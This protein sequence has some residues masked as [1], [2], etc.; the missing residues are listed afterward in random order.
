MA[1]VADTPAYSRSLVPDS[2]RVSVVVCTVDREVALRDTL[3]ALR[4]QTFSAFEVVVV[5][6]PSADGTA[7][8]LSSLGDAVR[9]RSNPERHLSRSRNL[10]IAAAAGDLVAFLDDDAVPE[11]RWL[12]ELVAPF[13]ADA[14][15]GAAGGLVLDHTGVRA[16]WRHL[17]AF[18][19]GDHDFDRLPPFDDVV[20]PG[21]DPFLYVPGGNSAFRRAALAEI[22]GFDEEIEYNFDETEVCL[23]LHDAGWG[24][25]SLDG[26]TVHHRALPSHLRTDAAFVD[27]LFEVK[28]RVYFGL[29]HGRATRT[30]AE[31]LAAL[32]RHVGHLR[33][34]A[35]DARVRGR[36]TDAQLARYLGRAD[37]GFHLGL[38]RGL[39][40]ARRGV[41]IPP[42]DGAAFAPYPVLTP[43]APR[44]RVAVIGGR[45]DDL[46]A[47]G[48]EVHAILPVAA[49]EPYRVGYEAGSWVR[50]VPVNP[51]WSA[52]VDPRVA[53]I[54]G[55]LADIGEAEVLGDPGPPVPPGTPFPVDWELEARACLDASADDRFVDAVYGR[56]LGR[57]PD[58]VGRRAM[59]GALDSGRD[60]V[61]VL[62]GVFAGVEAR[63][64]GIPADLADRLPRSYAAAA[65]VL[66]GA[67]LEADDGVFAD[68]AGRLLTGA[69]A[70]PSADRRALV[71]ALAATPEARERVARPQALPPGD[72]RTP[73][74]LGAGLNA[75]A[76][77][78]DFAGG[79]YRLL[80]GRAPD[81]A[82]VYAV[83]EQLRAGRTRAEVLVEL[84]GSEEA[85]RRGLRADVV[86]R[87]VGERAFRLQ[88]ALARL[89]RVAARAGR[90]ASRA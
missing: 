79:A 75:L 51:H 38:Q 69:P 43:D 18:R 66:R 14:R 4:R 2:L 86:E 41:V 60:R 45:A 67:W 46:A 30:Q 26:A 8:F 87:L 17:V 54:Q 89:S 5:N 13:A 90:R 84:A 28:N 36:L 80:F 72:V 71:R 20:G 55:A 22:G 23:Q 47:A 76:R 56:L 73:D 81:P 39:H 83:A 61:D 58:P 62:R 19:T 25:R 21:A 74:E 6:G 32:S 49:G 15:L 53:A 59:L 34:S 3:D 42:A 82:G 63:G 16:Q 27:P 68:I 50:R 10:G 65:S 33:G 57:E 31:V 29:Q 77:G 7:A 48:H 35:R 88:T 24:V 44:R 78:D 64:R 11:P 1:G 70:A 37:A 9:V 52:A 85:A 12:E 40:G